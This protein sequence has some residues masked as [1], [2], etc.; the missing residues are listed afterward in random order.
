MADREAA[1][2]Q[3]IGRPS[4]GPRRAFAAVAALLVAGG[5]LAAILVPGHRQPGTS[6][7]ARVGAQQR[8]AAAAGGPVARGQVAVAADYLGVSRSQLRSEMRSGHTLAY[9]AAH[10]PGRST[11]GLIDLLVR[12]R[13]A[14]LEKRRLPAERLRRRLERLRTAVTASV[15][16]LPQAARPSVRTISLAAAYLGVSSARLGAELTSGRTLAGVARTTPGRSEAGLVAALVAAE[17]S[18][19]QRAV[20]AGRLDRAKENAAL[21]TLQRRM[22]AAARR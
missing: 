1:G 22:T 2:G 5:V 19:L 12:E 13:T 18:R 16:R 15:N 4:S 10:T 21:S 8:R 3:T 20:A 11:A 6:P 17:R 7:S 9:I 14:A